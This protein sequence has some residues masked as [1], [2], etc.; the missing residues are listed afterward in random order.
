M[1]AA[2][3]N[4]IDAILGDCG[5]AC[6]CATCHCFVDDSWF[7]KIGPAKGVEKEMVERAV[8]PKENSRLGCQII[9][10]D[11]NDGV[12]IHLPESQY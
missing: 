2:I 6:S 12:I 1:A 11:S 9:L 10:D 4:G 3:D 8:D 7:D 5:G